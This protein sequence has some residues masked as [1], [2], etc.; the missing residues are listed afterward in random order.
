MMC[1]HCEKI[2]EDVQHKETVHR[3]MEAAAAGINRRIREQGHETRFP[4]TADDIEVELK[5]TTAIRKVNFEPT[6][7]AVLRLLYKDLFDSMK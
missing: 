4:I 2:V 1:R 6:H 7:P 3:F 5:V